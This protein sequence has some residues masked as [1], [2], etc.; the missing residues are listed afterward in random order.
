MKSL[1]TCAGKCTRKELGEF[2]FLVGIPDR[3]HWYQKINVKICGSNPF[4][5][6]RIPPI[7][8]FLEPVLKMK[9]T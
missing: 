1:P 6:C 2:S 8:K 5:M 3:W 7:C 4:E 9:V